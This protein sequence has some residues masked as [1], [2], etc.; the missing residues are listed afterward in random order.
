MLLSLKRLPLLTDMPDAALA[1][2]Y[3]HCRKVA[4]S[5]ARNFYYG[6]VLLPVPKRDALCALYAFMR[7]IDDIS[8]EPG[9]IDAR[10]KRLEQQRSELD[11][12]LT[13]GPTND[14]VWLALR[15]TVAHF[16]IPQRYLHDLI[17]GAQMDLSISTY[18][19]FDDLRKYCYHVAGAV[20][21]CCL[22]VFG[23]EDSQA[24]EFA[25]NMGI[26]FQLT[27]IL[28][29]V[30][31]DLAMG[32]V[33]LPREDFAR[34]NV[35]MEDLQKNSSSRPVAEFLRFQTNRAREF[36]SL[37]GRLLPLLNVDSQAAVWAM[38]RIYSGIL[39]KI[40]KRGSEAVSGERVR[41]SAAEKSWIL[42]RA[43]LGWIETWPAKA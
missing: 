5:A 40:Q 26:A 12:V 7:G 29:D 28:R 2:S 17:T 34:F 13:G 33:Y 22:H 23:F 42:L 39:S 6:F 15:H 38:A 36:Y 9:P 8:D 4:R 14:A 43:K 20:G 3:A 24:P 35:S 16:R 21:L 25:E 37:G 11:R 31:E 27:N 10:Q 1:A 41:L 19:T 30:R 18:E 32:R